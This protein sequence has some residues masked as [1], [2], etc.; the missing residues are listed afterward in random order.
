MDR[1]FIATCICAIA[2]SNLAQADHHNADRKAGYTG[3]ENGISVP[4]ELQSGFLV[5]IPGRIGSQS[6]LH[7]I[8]DTGTTRSVIDRR[9]AANFASQPK[10]D[11][12]ISFNRKLETQRTTVGHLEIGPI[13]AAN[14]EVEVMRLSEYSELAKD[15]DG[16]V[17]LDLLSVS[18]K[19]LIDYPRKTI[20]F[21]LA[22][23]EAEPVA[24]VRCF[25]VTIDVQGVPIR[26]VV[27]TGFEG[28]AIHEDRLRRLLPNM[29]T[30]GQP[31]DFRTGRLGGTRVHLL[32]VKVGGTPE[33]EDVFL[34]RGP[35]ENE[36]DGIDGFLGIAA[37]NAS[38]VE[39]DFEKGTLRWQ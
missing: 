31:V 29:R 2:A 8:L 36:P 23:V 16:I 34:M 20:W 7:F 13:R 12:V 24:H 15:A 33:T 5:V 3:Y 14:P 9:V 32:G 27:D 1:W 26:L 37:L 21:S 38:R 35:R 18:G 25:S 11:H 22:D 10:A 39:F 28:I 6:G 30:E 17:G 4:F 19:F